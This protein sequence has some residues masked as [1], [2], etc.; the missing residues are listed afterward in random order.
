MLR[1][2]SDLASQWRAL[3]KEKKDEL[4]RSGTVLHKE[5][6]KAGM[7]AIITLKKEEM[8]ESF[9]KNKAKA[10]PISLLRNEGYSE[11]ELAA[12]KRNCEKE[13]LPEVEAWGYYVNVKERGNLERT[14]KSWIEVLQQDPETYESYGGEE[15]ENEEAESVEDEEPPPTHLGIRSHG[16]SSASGAARPNPLP[17]PPKTPPP[18]PPPPPPKA[19]AMVRGAPVLIPVKLEPPPAKTPMVLP[20]PA[21][22]KGTRWSKNNIKKNARKYVGEAQVLI[23]ELEDMINV[24]CQNPNIYKEVPGFIF[25][26]AQAAVQTVETLSAGWLQVLKDGDAPERESEAE[27]KLKGAEAAADRLKKMLTMIKD[28]VA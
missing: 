22:Q 24:D 16:Q 2:D 20:Q 9:K 8:D 25:A 23:R 7:M 1:E 11:E 15:A 10:K 13:W 17:G 28:R 19:A 14:Q 6:M 18:P 5:A 21:P 12:V 27:A 3:P 4:M 26:E